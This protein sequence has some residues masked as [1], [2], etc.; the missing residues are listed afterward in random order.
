MTILSLGI[1]VDRFGS[2]S[3]LMELVTHLRN[4]GF[5]VAL[6]SN[7]IWES[8]YSIERHSGN[9]DLTQM[10]LIVQWVVGVVLVAVCL[11]L[12]VLMLIANDSLG[13]AS[14]CSGSS[15]IGPNSELHAEYALGAHVEY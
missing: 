5:A 12:S 4:R 1:R 13:S 6:D 8:V 2:G 14:D 7:Q 15:Q 10:H 3:M 9:Y 11:M